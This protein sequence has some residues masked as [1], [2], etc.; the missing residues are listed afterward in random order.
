MVCYRRGAEE[1]VAT[2]TLPMTARRKIPEKE[3]KRKV[4][5][6]AQMTLKCKWAAFAFQFEISQ[7]G[8]DSCGVLDR[9]H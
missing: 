9:T 1:I 7:A 5:P 6:I 4:H 8:F 2:T 3:E